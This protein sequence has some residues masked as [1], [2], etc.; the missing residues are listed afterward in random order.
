MIMKAANAAFVLDQ[1]NS[2]K[3]DSGK[4]KK[5]TLGEKVFSSD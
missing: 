3:L 4:E 5:I 2:K 1:N